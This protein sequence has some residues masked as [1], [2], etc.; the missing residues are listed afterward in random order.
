MVDNKVACFHCRR[1]KRVPLPTKE[2]LDKIG[3]ISSRS[4]MQAYLISE[5]W[6]IPITARRPIICPFCWNTMKGMYCG[7]AEIENSSED[8]E[9]VEIYK[10]ML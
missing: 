9:K 3:F 2:E 5:G 7:F 4:L 1:N 10:A 6:H 8:N